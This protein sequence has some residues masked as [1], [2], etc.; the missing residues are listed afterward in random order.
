[1]EFQM[2][3]F[4]RQA[5]PKQLAVIGVPSGPGACGVG[6]EQTPSA[7]RSAG[8]IDH[9]SRAGFDVTDL[10]DSDV[11][12]WG[13]DRA[14]PRAQNIGAIRRYDPLDRQPSGRRLVRA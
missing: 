2:G 8:L 12:P 14:N 5:I 7:M 9:L 4:S 1:M 11:V 10:G 13:P 3:S 6:Q